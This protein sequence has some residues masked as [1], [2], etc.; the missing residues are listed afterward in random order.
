[1][2]TF[3]VTYSLDDYSET[4]NKIRD[5]LK[6]YPVGQNYFPELGLLKLHVHQDVLET[7]CL[8]L[9]REKGI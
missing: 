8:R 2:N 4:Y 6:R 3:F 9:L 1:M 5:R 7:N